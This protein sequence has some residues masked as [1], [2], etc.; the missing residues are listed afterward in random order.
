MKIGKETSEGIARVGDVLTD[1]LGGRPLTVSVVD[2][3]PRMTAPVASGLKDKG[4]GTISDFLDATATDVAR[5]T[6]AKSLG[7]TINQLEAFVAAAKRLT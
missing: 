1:S 2:D 5:A 3:I 4:L 7:I 6:L